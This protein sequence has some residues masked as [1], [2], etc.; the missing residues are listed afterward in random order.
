M[1]SSE[2]QWIK[3]IFSF[4]ISQQVNGTAWPKKTPGWSCSSF[5]VVYLYHFLQM[6]LQLLFMY[7]VNAIHCI[8]K[9]LVSVINFLKYK[10]NIPYCWLSQFC[11]VLLAVKTPKL[12]QRSFFINSF[13]LLG[14]CLLCPALSKFNVD[15]PSKVC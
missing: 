6:F 9:Q 5:C 2:A 4:A 7:L 1:W 15:L 10:I 8:S 12:K 14:D 13:Y 3:W 11:L